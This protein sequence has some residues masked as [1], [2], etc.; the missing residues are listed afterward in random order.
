MMASLTEDPRYG[1]TDKATCFNDVWEYNVATAEW[2]KMDCTGYI[3]SPREG[4]ASALVK[5]KLYVFG[6]RTEEGT[7]LGDLAALDLT[8]A[9]WYTFQNMGRSPSPRSDHTMS[10][11]FKK[12]YVLGGEPSSGPRDTEELKM[13]YILDTCK[14]RYPSNN[15]YN[16]GEDDILPPVAPKGDT[17][18]NDGRFP[19]VLHNAT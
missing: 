6:G 14:I 11:A 2:K 12:I 5:D 9:R 7:D 13:V 8:S 18:E 4:H 16:F 3:P 1:G 17:E 19:L 10:A 15:P